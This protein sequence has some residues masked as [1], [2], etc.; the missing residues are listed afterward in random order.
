MTARIRAL[1]SVARAAGAMHG[2][3]DVEKTCVLCE[4]LLELEDL[5]EAG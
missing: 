1:E 3:H 4:A 2:P 5:E